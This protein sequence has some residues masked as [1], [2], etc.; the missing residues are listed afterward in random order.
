MYG[1]KPYL[2]TAQKLK[3]CAYCGQRGWVLKR[4]SDNYPSICNACHGGGF[5][6]DGDSETLE[7]FGRTFESA[8]KKAQKHYAKFFGN[9]PYGLNY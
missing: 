9:L 6:N 1:M 4:F 7:W 8:K 3:P 5:V 2:I